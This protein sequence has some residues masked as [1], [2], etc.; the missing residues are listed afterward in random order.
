MFS[1]IVASG[2]P[3]AGCTPRHALQ[4][5]RMAFLNNTSRNIKYFH[6]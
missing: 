4:I 1:N 5:S 6:F 2:S 3:P